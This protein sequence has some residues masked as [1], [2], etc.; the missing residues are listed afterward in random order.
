[1]SMKYF[2]VLGRNPELSRA[3]VFSYLKKENISLN[4]SFFRVNG[5]LVEIEREINLKNVINELGGTIAVGRVLF[6]GKIRDLLKQI[7]ETSSLKD[8]KVIILSNLGQ[9]SEVEKGLN[10]GAVKYLIKAH[11]TPTEIAEEIK[12]IINL[13][14]KQ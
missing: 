4:Y 14:D 5:L 2:F 8:L 7:K 11:Y 12:K 9:K 1:M 13:N 6:S 3:E 10:L